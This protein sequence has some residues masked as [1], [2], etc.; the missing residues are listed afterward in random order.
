MTKLSRATLAS[1]KPGIAVP[2]YQAADLRPGI[3]HFGLGNFHRGV[4][5][6]RDGPLDGD[7]RQN[8]A[9]HHDGDDTLFDFCFLR[10]H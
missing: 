2:N 6:S 9:D 3:L 7:T 10:R 5:G 4:N 1:L 8:G